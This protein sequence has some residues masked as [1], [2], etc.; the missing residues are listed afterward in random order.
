MIFPP[1][2]AKRIYPQYKKKEYDRTLTI[3]A[4]PITSLI[5]HLRPSET[6][7]RDRYK[8]NEIRERTGTNKRERMYVF[9]SPY[10]RAMTTVDVAIACQLGSED[11]VC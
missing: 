11:G 10:T 6:Y 9:R 8:S 7:V 2:S 4:V 5:V 1:Q 3:V